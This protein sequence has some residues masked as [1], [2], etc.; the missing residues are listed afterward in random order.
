MLPPVHGGLD[1]EELYSL[2]LNPAD[3]IDFS[4]NL[5]PFFPPSEFLKGA[6]AGADSYPDAGYSQLRKVIA[7][8]HGVDSRRVFAGNGASEIVHLL[9]RC[10]AS[11]GPVF[12]PVPTFSEYGRAAAICG[13]RT[14]LC[15]CTEND[16]LRFNADAMA[17]AIK[18]NH[19]CLVFLCNPNNPTGLYLSHKE[20]ETVASAAAGAV[21]VI[22]ESYVDFVIDPWDGVSL[23][24]RENIVILR[25]VAKFYGL[26]GIRMGYAVSSP[27]IVSALNGVRPPWNV[28]S[29]AEK[30]ASSVFSLPSSARDESK[31]LLLAAR[32]FLI[33]RV[34]AMGR[35]CLPT[36][37]GFFLVEAGDAKSVRSR[38]LKKGIAV[39]DCSSFGLPSYIRLSARP[40]KDSERLVKEWTEI[41]DC[42][43]DDTE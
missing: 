22:D 21:L 33:R 24:A 13:A 31:S 39:R 12:I 8:A 29:V 7:A 1:Y 42:A 41:D 37:T 6:C 20:V 5:N 23:A 2:G 34:E 9:C 4:S 18:K 28:N 43:P 3:V 19:P 36:D 26:A 35:R 17:S 16:G 10:F 11:S 14:V 30:A 32:D 15:D 27:Q 40:R 38:L 25:S